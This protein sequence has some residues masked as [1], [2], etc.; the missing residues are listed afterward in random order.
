MADDSRRGD[1]DERGPGAVYQMFMVMED[2]L[3]KLKLLDYEEEVLSKHNMKALS[4][5]V[6]PL[7]LCFVLWNK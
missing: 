6:E 5:L 1:D 4:R 7:H 3:D 2:L